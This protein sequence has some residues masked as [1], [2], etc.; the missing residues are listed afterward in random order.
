MDMTTTYLGLNLRTPL[1]ASASPISQEISNIRKMEDAGASAVVL[2]SLFE[3]QIIKE[4]QALFHHM[5]THSESFAEALTYFPEPDGLEA[6]PENYLNHIRK[7]KGAVDIPIIASLN[8]DTPGGWTDFAQQIEHVV[9]GNVGIIQSGVDAPVETAG[10]DPEVYLNDKAEL[11]RYVNAGFDAV[12]DL[13]NA[14][15]D[16][17]LRAETPLF[18]QAQVETWKLVQTAYEHGVWTLGA[19]V[20]YL[21]LNDSA[22]PG[23]NL[24]PSG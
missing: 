9:Q 3:E 19:T 15:P 13:I 8:G 4:Q 2:F 11:A 21:R 23:Y 7:A 6:G 17:G 1:V 14:I 22:P 12:A 20:P 10:F 24:I 5:H 16:D 18:G